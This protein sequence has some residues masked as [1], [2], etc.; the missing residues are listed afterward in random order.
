M[1]RDIELAARIGGAKSLARLRHIILPMSLPGIFS[2]VILRYLNL[3]NEYMYSSV[4][5]SSSRLQTA[6]VI[7]GQ[8]VTSEYAVE[9]GVMAAANILS[10][11]PALLSV[12]VVQK[13]LSKVF[14]G[15]IKGGR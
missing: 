3:W 6:A 14:V 8:M 12:S 10:I 11:L 7:L 4:M 1:P 2:T 5:V 15:G 13:N 9:W